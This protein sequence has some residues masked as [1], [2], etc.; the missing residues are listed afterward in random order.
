MLQF[1]RQLPAREL[2]SEET[3]F[4]YRDKHIQS[5][6]SFVRLGVA[7]RAAKKL[8]VVFWNEVAMV[9]ISAYSGLCCSKVPI[10]RTAVSA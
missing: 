4:G 5:I 3:A 9:D 8:R 7:L 10:H 6:I 2:T 1:L